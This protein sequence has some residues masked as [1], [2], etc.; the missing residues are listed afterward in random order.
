MDAAHIAEVS[1]LLHDAWR[2]DGSRPLND[3][4]WLDLREG[5]RRGFAG[6]VA[7]DEG[8]DHPVA[9]CQVSRGNESWS[10]DLVVH[11]H[12]RYDSLDIAPDMLRSALEVVASEGGGHV[13]WWVFEANRIHHRLAADVGLAPGRT[14]I[15]M[16]R[17]LPLPDSELALIEDFEVSRFRPG[18]D[19]DAWLAVNNA[20]FRAHPEQGGWTRSTIESRAREPWFEPMGF[21]MHWRGERLDG[22]CWTKIHVDTDPPMGEI[23]VVGVDPVSMGRGIGRRL[24]VAGLHHLATRGLGLA[25][26]Y[27]DATNAAAISM[28]TRMGFTHHH[29]EHA[30]VGDIPASGR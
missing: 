23:Y 17:S 11:P 25:M 15:Q 3:H 14:L 12:H 5:G 16:R 19:E 1:S 27:V 8:H 6:I 28:Y 18:I 13:H 29:L 7:R 21:L 2:A 4:L 26:L 22:F 10:L 20:A 9:Y 30:F 24:T